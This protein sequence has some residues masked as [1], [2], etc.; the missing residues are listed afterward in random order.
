MNRLPS[1]M[2]FFYVHL[3]LGLDDVGLNMNIQYSSFEKLKAYLN[4]ANIKATL[5]GV[6]SGVEESISPFDGSKSVFVKIN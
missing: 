2:P 3:D 5:Q 6:L 4:K 1:E